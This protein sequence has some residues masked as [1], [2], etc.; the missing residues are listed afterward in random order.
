MRFLDEKPS[1]FRGGSVTVLISRMFSF[2]DGFKNLRVSRGQLV[3]RNAILS[4]SSCL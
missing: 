2:S 1:D 3:G 4:R